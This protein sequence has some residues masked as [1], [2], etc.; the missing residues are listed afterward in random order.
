[1]AQSSILDL[2][3]LLCMERFKNMVVPMARLWEAG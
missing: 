1:L 2:I 3:S